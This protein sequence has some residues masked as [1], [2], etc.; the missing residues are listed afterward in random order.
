MKGISQNDIF[1]QALGLVEPWFVSQM[2]F[3]PSE[4][5]QCSARRV[6]FSH[7]P[8]KTQGERLQE[9]EEFQ[10]YDLLRLW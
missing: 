6:Q 7:K 10:G 8:D 3:Q 2:E 4:K 5:D 1:T 9:H